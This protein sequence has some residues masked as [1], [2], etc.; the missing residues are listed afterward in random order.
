[1]AGSY[2]TDLRSRVLAAMEAGESPTAAAKRFS[3]GR[4]STYRWAQA[5][6]DEGRREAKRVGGISP[7]RLVFLDECGVLTN[8][9]RLHGRSPHGTRAHG[10]AP[11][12]RW[13]RLT[14]LGALGAE[15]IVGAI[16]AEAATST[17]VFHAYL[18]QVPLP[19]LR[20]R[21]PDTVLVMDNLRAHKAPRVRA[22]LNSSGFAHRYPI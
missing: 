1:M 16:S 10:A 6:R 2:S 20:R 17:A 21:K 12:G 22:L 18:D 11:F 19:E 13:T 4:L 15:G 8:M 7:E 5:A 3:V 9:V 14:L